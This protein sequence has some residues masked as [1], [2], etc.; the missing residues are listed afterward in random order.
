V[1]I[2]VAAPCLAL[3][4][5][6]ACSGRTGGATP[7]PT[8]PATPAAVVPRAEPDPG[9]GP[10]DVRILAAS[11]TDHDGAVITLDVETVVA[12]DRPLAGT[13]SCSSI[14]DEV[15][16]VVTDATGREVVRQ[17][18]NYTCS[19]YADGQPV[20]LAAGRARTTLR[21]SVERAVRAP[22]T[23]VRLEGTFAGRPDVRCDAAAVPLTPRAP[24]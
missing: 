17:P 3:T 24:E 18:H 15:S 10:V 23:T 9:A 8:E 2:A 5:L 12:G 14:F 6:S 4:V 7:P 20:S 13:T 11:E 19:P 21:F 1:R 16:L 22:G